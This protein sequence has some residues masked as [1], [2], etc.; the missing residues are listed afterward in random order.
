MAMKEVQNGKERDED[1][2][3]RLFQ[4]ADC[5]FVLKEIRQPDGSDLAIIVAD[6]VTED[7]KM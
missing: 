4:K 6:W 5:R 1:D 2:W 7:K 3:A